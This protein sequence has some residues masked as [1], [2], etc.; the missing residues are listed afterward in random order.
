M[1]VYKEI[2]KVYSVHITI[3]MKVKNKKVRK[4]FVLPNIYYIFASVKS[5]FVTKRH[6]FYVS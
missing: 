1:F 3:F 4:N 6:V 2:T 5:V